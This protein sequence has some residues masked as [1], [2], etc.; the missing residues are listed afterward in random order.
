MKFRIN[1]CRGSILEV[2]KLADENN[3]FIE[4][5]E[6]GPIN[7]DMMSLKIKFSMESKVNNL[8]SFI[9]SIKENNE[10]NS[11]DLI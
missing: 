7:D 10:L 4:S 11:C 8:E 1:M 2:I 6:Q 9:N 3:L 5:I